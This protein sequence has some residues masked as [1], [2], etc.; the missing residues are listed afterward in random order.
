[1]QPWAGAAWGHQFIRA[2]AWRSWSCSKARS[3]QADGARI[4]LEWNASASL[5]VA[6]RKDQ[7]RDPHAK[8][9]SSQGNNELSFED[10]TVREQVYLHAQRD[11]HELVENNHTAE[12]KGSKQTTIDR[13]VEERVRGSAELYIEG[14]RKG[15]IDGDDRLHVKGG[16]DLTSTATITSSCSARPR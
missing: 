12:V 8:H 11:Y 5:Q 10:R 4:A 15:E 14:S 2:S 13:D 9:T 7:E 1:M 16:V 6:R 3:R